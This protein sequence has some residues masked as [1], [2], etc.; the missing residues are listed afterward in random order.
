MK[1]IN[2]YNTKI[3]FYKKLSQN[4]NFKFYNQIIS[5]CHSI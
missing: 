4:Q 2:K 3:N 5:M 1:N